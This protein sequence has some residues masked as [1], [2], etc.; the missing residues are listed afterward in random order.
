MR[1]RLAFL[2]RAYRRPSHLARRN[3]RLGVRMLFGRLIE[4][5]TNAMHVVLI[6]WCDVIFSH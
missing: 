5:A 1:G 3:G 2:L 6:C 4:A